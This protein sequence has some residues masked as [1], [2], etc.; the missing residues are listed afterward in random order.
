MRHLLV[1]VL[2]LSCSCAGAAVPQLPQFRS[3]T[4]EDGLPS[5]MVNGIAQDRDGY[6]WMATKDG[7]ARYDGLEFKIYRYAPGDASSLPGNAVLAVHVDAGNRIWVGIEGRGL[8]MLDVDRRAFR[9]VPLAAGKVAVEDIWAIASTPDGAL[10]LGTFGNGLYRIGSDGKPRQFLPREGDASSLPDANVLSLA[11]DDKGV[12]WVGT[13]SGLAHWTGSNFA[14]TDPA[15]LSSPV[16]FG[17]S[18]DQDGS[19]WVGTEAGL[20]HRL[21]DGQWQR[22]EWR[23]QLSDPGVYAVLNDADG[24]RWIV[25]RRGLDRLRDGKVMSVRAGV[26]FLAAIADHEGGLWFASSSIGVM[27]LPAGWRH[28][29]VLQGQPGQ[30]DALAN[31][32][33]KGMAPGRSGQVWLVGG[34]GAVDRFDPGTGRVEH[35]LGEAD[36]LPVPRL[37]SVFE[38]H[39]GNVWIGYLHGLARYEP[40]TR[41]LAHWRTG[42]GEHPTLMGPLKHIVESDDR[43]VW[44][45]SEGG[46]LQGRDADGKVLHEIKP[47]DGRGMRFAD[48]NQLFRGPDGNLWLAGGEGLLRWD[49]DELRLRPV[50]GAPDERV[51][52]AVFLPPDTFWLSRLGVLEAYRWNGHSLAPFRRIDSTQGLPAVEAGGLAVDRSGALWLT[53]TRG[54]I[55]Y[56]PV[57]DRLRV[58]GVRDGLPSQEFEQRPPLMRADGIGIAAS[59][60]GLVLFTPERMRSATVTPRLLI[61]SLRLRRGEDDVD[62][63]VGKPLLLLPGDRDLRVTARLLSF[64][65]AKAHRY[66]FRLN[67]FDPDWVEIGAQGQRV[68]ST[69]PAGRYQ[70]EVIAAN[71]EGLWSP[72]EMLDLQVQPPWWRTPWARILGLLLLLVMAA[73]LAMLYRQR[74]KSRHQA[75]RRE[76]QRAQA[77][78]NSLAKSRFLATLGHEIRTP[79]TGVLGMAELLLSTPLEAR[80]RGQVESIQRAGQHLLRLVNDALDLARIESGKLTLDDRSFDLHALLDEVTNLLAPLARAKGLAFSLQRSPATPLGLRGDADRIRQILFNLGNNAIKFTERGEV[81]LRSQP[82][83]PHGVLLEVS[84]TGPGMN[85]EQQARLFQ[86]FEQ[87]EGLRTAQRYGGSGLGLAISQE[88]AAAMG[89]RIE[90]ISAPGQGATFRVSLPLAN[91]ELEAPVVATAGQAATGR[92]GLR[93]LVVEDEATVAEVIVGLL[94]SRG[95][96]AVH[97]AQ[98]LAALA[99]LQTGQFDLVFLDLDLPGLDGLELA[100]LIRAQGHRLP[101]LALTARADAE[102]EP[103]ALQAGMQGFLRKPVT[104]AMLQ[105]AMDDA[106]P[107]SVGANP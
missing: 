23:S 7:L 90:V 86:R 57:G 72:R 97:A 5:G 85:A 95:H 45:A 39:A 80:Q 103:L 26:G 21:A 79:M 100:R 92:R 94:Q 58:Y 76:E 78:Q 8:S 38:D 107:G 1:L 63:P 42:S 20:E 88:L 44:V 31:V 104:S 91:A 77:E 64:D 32:V 27:R 74:L 47:G 106:L 99:E 67:G 2:W 37:S 4:V 75:E 62:L 51:Y 33:I 43:V 53:S 36:G 89:G 22:P 25:T 56:D 55:R 69:L 65:D 68:F 81:A 84:D 54:L 52:G 17:I 105:A 48:P 49:D 41:R 46:G 83:A 6:V 15:K 28:F 16:I 35:V 82:V 59:R 14:K 87:A 60:K 40:K 102:A 11:V 3:L 34:N 13:T 96:I 12:L 30:P 93:L 70:L 24:M 73:A 10:W 98:G 29:S 18:Q 61:E 50:P 101:L 71:A 66:R 9:N 19:L